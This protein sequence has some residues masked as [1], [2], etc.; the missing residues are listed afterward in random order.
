MIQPESSPTGYRWYILI[1][2]ALTNTLVVAIPSMC[3]PVLFKEIGADLNLT[4]VELGVIWGLGSLPGIV[5]VLLGG[6]IGDQLG[7]KRVLIAACFLGG[8]AGALRGFAVDLPTL[9]VTVVLYGFLG[10]VVPM[11][12][13]KTCGL[14]FPRHQLGMAAGVVSMGM[15][16]GFMLGS[17]LSATVMSPWLGGW[18][19][20]VVLYG[21]LGMALVIPWY[22][23]RPA[24]VAAG[25]SAGN[26]RKSFRQTLLYVARIKKMW[27]MGLAIFGIGG[28]IQGALGYL[29][30]YLRGQGWPEASADGALSL[31]HLMSMI[32][33]V[34]IA[35]WSDRLGSRKRILLLAA[36]LVITGVSLLSVASGGAV[37]A[38]VSVAGLVRDGFM[39]VFLTMIIET[40][41]IGALY[42][43]TA[44][45]LV[46]VFSGLGNVLAPP[47]G[48][49]LA[50]T[51]PGLPF[52]L[53]AALALL[54]L[55]GLW[56]AQ[57]SNVV[58]PVAQPSRQAG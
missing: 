11:N 37:W 9:A 21:M 28:C 51:S 47:I 3:L 24:P 39:A 17:M 27:L 34:P 22:F 13:L 15:A 54:G 44:T 32:F 53:W 5:T 2:A 18:R 33:V 16:L 7:P 25:V 1:L 31:F 45:G 41:G 23:T 10:S 58:A 49:S 43:G 36:L 57:E 55:V 48:N 35:M 56:A 12:A 6:V 50:T 30:L 19:P 14:W 20:V 8:L 4:L 38:A 46:M 29:P 40:E 26:P 52:L 42:A